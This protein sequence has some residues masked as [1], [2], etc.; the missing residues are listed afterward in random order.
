MGPNR[1]LERHRKGEKALGFH[2]PL[3]SEF[4]VEIACKLGLDYASFD[5]QH[6]AH[7][8]PELDTLCR[9]AEGYGVTCGARIVDHSEAAILT[10][11]DRGIQVITVPNLKTAEEAEQIVS[12]AFFGPIGLRSATSHRIHQGIPDP[13]DMRDVF[14]FNNDNILIVPQLESITAF[15][16]LDEILEVDGIDYFGGGPQDVAQSMG[17]PGEPNHP[18]CLE[19]YEAACE[20][21]RT[22]GKYMF[23]DVLVTVDAFKTV[24]DAGVDL[25]EEHGRKAGLLL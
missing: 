10:A 4:Y 23:G 25:M 3:F 1:I 7:T 16:N 11:L 20:K 22:A 13:R 9:I 17:H 21:V 12:Y 15:N 24:Y 6:G 18:D 14:K 19:A 8:L 5:C 2:I